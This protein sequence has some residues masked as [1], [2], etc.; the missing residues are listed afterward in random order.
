MQSRSRRTTPSGDLSYTNTV[1]S[2]GTSLVVVTEGTSVH[3]AFFIRGKS[4][5][6]YEGKIL[7]RPSTEG[8]PCAV[9]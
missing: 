9:T 5:G 1:I 3:L 7:G 4:N 8:K 2:S 6:A